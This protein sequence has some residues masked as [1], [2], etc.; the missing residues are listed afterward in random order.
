MGSSGTGPV[1][2]GI[3]HRVIFPAAAQGIRRARQQ[4]VD[5]HLID[6]DAAIL[7][8]SAREDLQA[9]LRELGLPVPTPKKRG[10]AR[11]EEEPS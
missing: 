11:P 4:G 6:G 1:G 2:R 7:D 8:L 9:V 3:H 10:E 5:V